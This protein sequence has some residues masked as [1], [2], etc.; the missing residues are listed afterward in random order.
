M[1]LVI[2]VIFTLGTILAF[3]NIY[4]KRIINFFFQKLKKDPIDKLIS[5]FM[6]T[7]MSKDQFLKVLKIVKDEKKKEERRNKLNKIDE[8]R[9]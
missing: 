6:T 9:R 5:D 8:S 3:L 7:D 1:I 4:E 2:V